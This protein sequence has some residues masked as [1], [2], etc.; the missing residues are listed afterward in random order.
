MEDFDLNPYIVLS[1]VKRIVKDVK[2]EGHEEPPLIV[3]AGLYGRFLI[4]M[5]GFSDLI[6]GETEE[7]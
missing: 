5:E 1:W 6:V 3:V 7:P 4:D 2:G